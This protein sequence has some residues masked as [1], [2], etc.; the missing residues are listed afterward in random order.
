GIFSCSCGGTI[1]PNIV[2]FGESLPM[3]AFQLAEKT[4]KPADLFIVLGS[5][6]TV[7]PANMFPLLA[8]E[9]GAKLVIINH[10]PTPYDSYA[11]RVIQN[12][13]IKEALQQIDRHL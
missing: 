9:N 8:K 5:S 1:R 12:I 11:D 6:L 13:S 2:L 4:S 3:E 7:S 10:D